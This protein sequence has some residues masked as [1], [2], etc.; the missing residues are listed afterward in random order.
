MVSFFWSYCNVQIE[1]ELYN[2]MKQQGPKRISQKTEKR[3]LLLYERLRRDIRDGVYPFGTRLP[4]KRL[5]AEETNVSVITAEH[6]YTLLCEEGYIESRER[7][8]YYVIYRDIDFLTV[9]SQTSVP[10]SQGDAAFHP[11][12]ILQSNTAESGIISFS[13]FAKTTRKVL[14]DRGEQVLV[15]SPG[16]GCPELRGALSGYLAR[17]QRIHVSPQQIVIGSG[18]EYLY[19]L[20]AQLFSE[21]LFAIE[22]PSYRQIQRV[23]EACGI[24]CDPLQMGADGILTSELLRTQATVLH[25]TPFHSF[26]SGI[27]ATATKREEYL[28]FIEQRDGYLIEDNYDAELTVSDKNESTVFSLSD[29]GRVIYM[30]TFSK[31]VAPSVRVGYLVLPEQLLASFEKKLGFYS[32]TVPVLEQYILTELIESGS[33]ERH[34]NRVRRAR[35]RANETIKK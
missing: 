22:D 27:T 23:Y 34:I 16:Y 25:V 19:S 10:D 18:A 11:S 12:G 13:L 4:S 30:N 3:Y 31:T 2:Q 32:C 26:P 15:R 24:R 28:R 29:P 17:S 5:L 21:R 33:F 35:R 14:L 8:G 6:A 9:P 1:G 7:S 20:L